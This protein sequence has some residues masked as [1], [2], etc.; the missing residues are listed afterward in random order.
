MYKA[1]DSDFI[2]YDKEPSMLNSHFQL[3]D[4]GE[5]LH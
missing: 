1:L 3:L 5:G 4:N 2:M